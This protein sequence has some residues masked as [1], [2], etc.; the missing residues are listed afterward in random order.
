MGDLAAA[1][2]DA[3]TDRD[4]GFGVTDAERWDAGDPV[5]TFRSPDRVDDLK[6]ERADSGLGRLEPD[7]IER[8]IDGP[9]AQIRR[10]PTEL[11]G[12]VPSGR[13]QT[14]IAHESTRGSRP[15]ACA[16][17]A[18]LAAMYVSENTPSSR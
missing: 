13:K 8:D 5:R 17:H 12:D 11:Y 6:A 10:L 7:F 2:H 18:S 16:M 15:S 14:G 3:V 1:H 4:V 9:C